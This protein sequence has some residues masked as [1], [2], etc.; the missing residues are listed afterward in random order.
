M[1]NTLF[2]LDASATDVTEAGPPATPR[3]KRE[4]APFAS[5]RRTSS[6]AGLGV[7]TT[8]DVVYKSVD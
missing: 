7:P 1:N 6:G 3:A 5:T 8:S 4:N 2:L